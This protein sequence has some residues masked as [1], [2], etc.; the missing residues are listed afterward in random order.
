MRL[1]ALFAILL[2]VPTVGAT[3]PWSRYGG[4]TGDFRVPEA[5]PTTNASEWKRNFGSGTSGIVTDG[6]RLYS[7]YSVPSEGGKSGEE[8]AVALD[9]TN[10][11]TLWEESVP[12]KLLAKQEAFGGGVIQPQATPTVF[13]GKLF[14]VGFTGLLHARDAATGKLLWATDLV[15]DHGATPV[16]FGFAA[17][18]IVQDGKLVV[19]S[20]G[21]QAMIVFDTKT[22]NVLCKSEAAE[23]SY[24]TPVAM[25]LDGRTTI[26]QLTRDAL[27]GFDLAT[28]STLWKYPLPKPRLTNV[29]TPIVLSENRILVSGQGLDGTRLVQI[30]KSGET[31]EAKELWHQ[32]K[33]QFFYTNWASDGMA[34]YGFTGNNGKRLTSIKLLNG[35]ILF[36]E[37]GQT[38]ANVVILG[39]KLL[40][41]RGDGLLSFGT[42]TAEAYE[43]SARGIATT[44][45]CWVPP[46]ILGDRAVIRS[47]SEL[48]IVK[49]SAL[50]GDFK[51][52]AD[53]G[54]SALEAAYG[55]PKPKTPEK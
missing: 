32:R 53:T 42:S 3:E 40:A 21:K 11:K 45:R 38:D 16:Q 13:E 9:P 34:V 48:A 5:K 25:T 39:N 29:P 19:H 24:A 28:G 10:G 51:A 37:L 6:T 54:V 52:P 44:G 35:S 4:P 15:A 18:P 26:I 49:L 43:V 47:K 30:A 41:C 1:Q 20:G 12:V 17:S 46:T 7:M 36:Q 8:F 22:G 27:F 33:A 14:S 31:Y 23:P 2:V 50:V 55:S